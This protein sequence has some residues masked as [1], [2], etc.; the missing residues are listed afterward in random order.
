M[1]YNVYIRGLSRAGFRVPK[2]G[3]GWAKVS[4]AGT[5]Q[6]DLDNHVT[7]WILNSERDNFVR[8]SGSG[9]STVYIMGLTQYGFRVRP[10]GGGVEKLVKLG[11]PAVRVDLTDYR[12][13][14]KL[15]RSYG[16]YFATLANDHS[17]VISIRGTKNEQNGFEVG[18]GGTPATATLS[19]TGTVPLAG[20]TVTINDITYRFEATLA[21]ANDVKIG[22]S[23]DATLTSLSK[24]VNQN[25][26]VG[27]DYFTG[28]V[29]PTDV[30]S[31][32]LQGTG[33]TG[34]LVFTATV[35][36]TAGNSYPSTETSAQLSFGGA[37]FSGGTGVGDAESRAPTKVF[38]G[39]VVNVDLSVPF[40]YQ[41]VRRHYK[42][43]LE[44]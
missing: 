30:T 39:Q 32:A 19:S 15:R 24:A 37:T 40:N 26:V 35:N 6:V 5:T 16:R 43:W 13:C 10:F 22:A 8:V 7:Q 20:D 23:S 29:A 21:Q 17:A 28:T 36:G 18:T 33:A 2:V 9:A 38:R 11:K 25:G 34:K 1:A 14:K 31:S 27:T 4:S 42:A 12:V 3:G 41:Q 44:A